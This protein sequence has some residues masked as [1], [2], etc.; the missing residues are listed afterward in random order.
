M[1]RP[2]FRGIY[3]EFQSIKQIEIQGNRRKSTRVSLRTV[4]RKST[5]KI[6][7]GLDL[8]I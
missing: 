6:Q 4:I 3:F 8:K 7:G 2:F 1:G 5:G